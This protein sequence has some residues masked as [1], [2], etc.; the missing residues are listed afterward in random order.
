M[1]VANNDAKAINVNIQWGVMGYVHSEE[2]FEGDSMAELILVIKRR[3]MKIIDELMEADERDGDLRAY[4][5]ANATGYPSFGS[6]EP[7]WSDDIIGCVMS[8]TVKGRICEYRSRGQSQL[9]REL[10]LY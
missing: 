10:G 3:M 2:L 1:A 9:R 7:E 4:V 8:M 5:P 6:I